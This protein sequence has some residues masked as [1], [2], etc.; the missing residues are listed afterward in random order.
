MKT[1]AKAAS[2]ALLATP[3]V[4]FA[5]LGRIKDLIVDVGFIIDSLIVIVAGL[6]LLAF[7]WGLVKFIN[8]VSTTGKTEGRNF[9]I[10]G[11][12]A[13]FVMVS[14][15]GLVRFIES[16]IFGSLDNSNPS[17]VPGFN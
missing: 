3:S 17:T 1:W 2:L 7:F 8:A 15:W 14:V 11:L 9:M 4:A 13:L 10:W 6:A 5:Q 12:V 16:Q